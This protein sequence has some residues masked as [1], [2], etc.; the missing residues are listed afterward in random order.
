LC[1]AFQ[2]DH[3]GLAH[4]VIGPWPKYLACAR[5]FSTVLMKV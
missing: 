2:R 4:E 5:G 1:D 3:V